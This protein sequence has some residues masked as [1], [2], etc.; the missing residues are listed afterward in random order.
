MKIA[1][2]YFCAGPYEIF[3]NDFSASARQHFCKGHN[4]HYY[5]FTDSQTIPEADDTTI[6]FQQNLGWPF[7]SL[8]RYRIFGR[9]AREI[10]AYDKVVFFNANCLFVDNVSFEEFFGTSKSLLACRHPAFF[11][12]PTESLP[13]ETRGESK[14]CVHKP[15]IYVQGAL[16]GGSPE[17]FL[18]MCSTLSR[19][20]EDDLENGILARWFD[21]SHWNAYINN[22][23]SRLANELQVLTPSYLYPEGWNLPFKPLIQLRDKNKVLDMGTI[24]G[25]VNSFNGDSETTPGLVQR[26]ATTLKKLG[27]ASLRKLKL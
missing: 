15:S 23:F 27:K 1:V 6:V 26:A 16:M 4:V 19:S 8:Y 20:I 14:A 3:W 13:Y 21:E 5:L 10:T 7:I 11:N 24:K 17:Q 9:I 22:N 18:S 12:S 25:S 2:L